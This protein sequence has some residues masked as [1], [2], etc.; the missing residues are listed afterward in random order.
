MMTIPVE[1]PD[2]SQ[3]S[4]TLSKWK[5]SSQYQYAVNC[6]ALGVWQK[7]AHKRGYRKRKSTRKMQ[8][9]SGRPRR[10]KRAGCW[11]STARKG[12]V[13]RTTTSPALPLRWIRPRAAADLPSG[14]EKSPLVQQSVSLLRPKIQAVELHDISRIVNIQIYRILDIGRERSAVNV[15]GTH[16]RRQRFKERKAYSVSSRERA[17]CVRQR[18]CFLPA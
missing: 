6:I 18:L 8:S 12:G 2:I 13:T 10:R 3:Q 9:V 4:K 14:P 5:R 16:G 1:Y 7:P 15:S 17:L 11:E